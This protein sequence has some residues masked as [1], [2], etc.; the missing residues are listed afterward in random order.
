MH[1]SLL[2]NRSIS[3]LGWMACALLV[4]LAISGCS[5]S[6]TSTYSTN[7]APKATSQD[8]TIQVQQV[9]RYEGGVGVRLAIDNH[10]STAVKFP[11]MHS[12]F[13]T[14]HALTEQGPVAGSR[15][16]KGKQWIY[17][18]PYVVASG[19]TKLL[20][21]QFDRSGLEDQSPLMI[22]A[23]TGTGA[24]IRVWEIQIPADQ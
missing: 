7:V 6:R 15:L 9:I 24:S 23:T 20:N 3:S 21:L 17:G 11:R 22:R 16:E 8:V 10:S 13:S 4:T 18:S 5:G 19:T 2:I 1:S 12:T 14:V